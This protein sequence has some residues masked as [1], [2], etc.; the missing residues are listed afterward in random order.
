MVYDISESQLIMLFTEALF[1]PLRGWMKAYRSITLQ[2]AISRTLDLQD[3][4]PKEQA[5]A[6]KYQ[7]PG[8]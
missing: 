8:K 3:F 6:K 2:D 1:E 4:V 5:P 7:S